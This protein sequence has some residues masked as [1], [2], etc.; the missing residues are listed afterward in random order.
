MPISK[1]SQKYQ[2]TIP[3]EIRQHLGLKRGSRVSI[4]LKRKAE[5]VISPITTSLIEKYKGM[6]KEVWRALGGADKYLNKERNSWEQ[7]HYD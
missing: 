7:N 5:A 4:R 3:S 2:I 6:G 1:L